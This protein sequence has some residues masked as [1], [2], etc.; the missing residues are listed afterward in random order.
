[1]SVSH[2]TI[3]LFVF[4]TCFRI[5]FILF[6][7]NF[8]I[9]FGVV[10]SLAHSGS[11]TQLPRIHFISVGLGCFMSSLQIAFVFLCLVPLSFSHTWECISYTLNDV[12]LGETPFHP[13]RSDSSKEENGD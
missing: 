4:L 6:Q 12:F 7:M 2:S 5:I 8:R 13:R 10:L 11:K 1:M 3:F 9:N